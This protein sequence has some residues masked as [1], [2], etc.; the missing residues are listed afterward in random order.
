MGVC[1]TYTL[2]SMYRVPFFHYVVPNRSRFIW[3][4]FFSQFSDSTSHSDY[5][6]YA[7]HNTPFIYNT[8]HFAIPLYIN[9]LQH[10][11]CQRLSLHTLQPLSTW[12]NIVHTNAGHA[13]HTI[14]LATLACVNLTQYHT[15]LH[16]HNS[17]V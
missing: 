7:R 9:M 3:F 14:Y 2:L 8:A 5:I 16:L 10:H 4:S 6:I 17:P 13:M 15:T 11:T 1:H 12:Y